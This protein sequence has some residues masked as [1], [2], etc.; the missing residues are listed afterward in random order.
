M[1]LAAPISPLPL[2][3]WQARWAQTSLSS[4]RSARSANPPRPAQS[5]NRA[6]TGAGRVGARPLAAIT[7][8]IE[9]LE[10]NVDG[11]LSVVRGIVEP[12]RALPDEE[13]RGPAR[14]SKGR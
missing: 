2:P 14:S 11:L 9:Q 13:T 1:C 12:E 4:R 5:A 3:K 7:E 10:R 6:A 8:R